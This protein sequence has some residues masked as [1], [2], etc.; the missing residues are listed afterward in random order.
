M[1]IVNAKPPNPHDL[2]FLQ[3][4]MQNPSM[5]NVYLLGPDSDIWED[6]RYSCDLFALKR[7][8]DHSPISRALGG[9]VVRWW[10]HCIGRRFRV[11]FILFRFLHSTIAVCCADYPPQKPDNTPL[12]AN[13]VHY[14]QDTLLYLGTLLGTICASVLPVMSTVVLYSVESMR[15]RLGIVGLFTALFAAALGVFTNGRVIEIFSAT[16]T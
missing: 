11:R 5:G 4:W 10:H 6:A 1:S 13:T 16:A 2:R 7:R 8:E 12:H 3:T 9:C 14:S 15:W